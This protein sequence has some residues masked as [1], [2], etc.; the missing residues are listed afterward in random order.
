MKLLIS[1]L[2]CLFC[3]GCSSQPDTARPAPLP[4][5]RI[6][7]DAMA[8]QHFFTALDALKTDSSKTVSI[9]HIGDSHIQADYFSGTLRVLLQERFG[10]AGR[11]LIFPYRIAHTNEPVNYSSSSLSEWKG[12]RNVIN[13]N[14]ANIGVSGIAAFSRSNISE[15][16]IKVKN[17]QNLNYAFNRVELFSISCD[18]E[19]TRLIS[20][21]SSIACE[22]KEIPFLSVFQLKDTTHAFSLRFSGI[23][24][25]DVHGLVLKNGQAGILYHTIGVNGA[26]FKDYNNSSLFMEQLKCLKPDLII[27][28]LGTNE[29]YAGKFDPE[30][31]KQQVERFIQTLR[32]QSPSCSVLFTTPS[33]NYK[34]KKGKAHHNVK[35]AMVGTY[36]K[37][38]A[39]NH[40]DAVWDLYEV[41]G[42]KHAMQQWKKQGLSSK[43]YVHFTRKGYEL[44]GHLLFDAMMN[45]YSGLK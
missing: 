26:T 3:S 45:A 5:N 39:A 7:G 13:P 38:Y 44:Q 10:N 6:T 21:S 20:H 24:P 11:G 32:L 25:V 8:L 4:V 29:S 37:T 35:P 2:L 17:Q 43:D 15:F 36:L 19:N 40:H 31:L 41:M 16:T 33:D 42:G 34:L 28:S 12:I 18:R 23:N 27:I 30:D 22:E 14:H 1:A 9:V